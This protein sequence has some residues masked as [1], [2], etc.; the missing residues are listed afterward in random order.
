M[1]APLRPALGTK[2]LLYFEVSCVFIDSTNPSKAA[3]SKRY[4]SEAFYLQ[5]IEEPF[6]SM[7]G[8]K[9]DKGGPGEK[10]DQGQAIK[11]EKGTGAVG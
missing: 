3:F 10:G 7:L 5:N 8:P 4:L 1:L 9:G 11:G 6:F 2:D